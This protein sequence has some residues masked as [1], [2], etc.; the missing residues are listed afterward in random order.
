LAVGRKSNPCAFTL[1]MNWLRF[2]EEWVTGPYHVAAEAAVATNASSTA[3]LA[4]G[5][6][7][8][9]E[10]APS[11]TIAAPNTMIATYALV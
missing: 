7:H 1:L 5:L 2:E 3:P 6:S 8:I 10:R 9:A 11:T 4:R